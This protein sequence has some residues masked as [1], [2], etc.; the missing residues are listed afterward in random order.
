MVPA[1]MRAKAASIIS[2][3]MTP[4]PTGRASSSFSSCRA[5]PELDTMLC[6]PE[7]APQAIVT[8]MMGQTGPMGIEK[9]VTAGR[10]KSGCRTKIPMIPT[11]RPM[12]TM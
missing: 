8:N 9:L 2:T 10:V 11:K 12:K 6:Q 1:M 7:I 5:V 4:A 3:N